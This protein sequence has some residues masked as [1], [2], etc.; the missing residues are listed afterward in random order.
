MT[1]ADFAALLARVA[2]NEGYRQFPYTDTR[3]A[4]TV[5]YGHNLAAKG[6]SQPLAY[7]LLE[8]DLDEAVTELLSYFPIV[9]TLS[10]TR[11]QVLAEM[12][13]NLGADGLGKFT[14]MWAAIEK[15]SWITA[16][17]EML[18]SEWATQ[19]GARATRLAS[20]MASDRFP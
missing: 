19:V 2:T 13:Y 18:A 17:N 8:D 12:C 15:Q 14:K 6:L 16:A 3:G 7:A 10:G 11:Q 4:L 20:A 1:T 9:I 5:G